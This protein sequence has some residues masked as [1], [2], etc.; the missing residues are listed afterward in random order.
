LTPNLSYGNSLTL[1][2]WAQ[3]TKGKLAMF[4]SSHLFVITSQRRLLD[5]IPE[6]E[7]TPLEINGN[8]Q[9]KGE[10]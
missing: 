2:S 4:E 10:E 9:T 3:L 5:S 6:S 7:I 8:W 1:I